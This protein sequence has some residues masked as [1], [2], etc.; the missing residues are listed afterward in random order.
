[1]KKADGT[2]V[3]VELVLKLC[4][5]HDDIR[6]RGRPDRWSSSQWHSAILIR[7]LK[8]SMPHGEPPQPRTVAIVG[9]RSGG[10]IHGPH[11]MT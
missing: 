10:K 2:D 6:L 3:T 7:Q 11:C 1:M 8:R 4:S 5:R 9:V